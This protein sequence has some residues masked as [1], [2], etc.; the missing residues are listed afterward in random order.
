MTTEFILIADL[1]LLL[2]LRLLLADAPVSWPAW[3]AKG[4][5]ELLALLLFEPHAF[6]IGAALTTIALNVGA[7]FW[8]QRTNQ[9]HGGRLL[10]GALQIAALSF[11]F[12]PA[13][14]VEFR[15]VLTEW[16]AAFEAWSALGAEVTRS[17]DHEGGRIFLGLLLAANEANLLV[18][19]LLVRLQ[20]K[21]GAAGAS[22]GI[23]ASEFNRGRVI[24]LLERVLIYAFVLNGQYGAIGF[25]L[26]AKGFTRFKELENR[27]FAE[28]V[29]IG[30]LL[31]SSLAMA[32]GWWAGGRS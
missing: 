2:R 22:A 24:G 14:G 21:P 19:W 6:L 32:A 30:T 31:S 16:R 26:A 5:V 29:L 28:Y 12:S 8:D 17:I 15:A 11:W 9:R 4:L 3:L 27:G 20:I 23:D 25:T 18:R 13:G 10:F 7:A 1:V